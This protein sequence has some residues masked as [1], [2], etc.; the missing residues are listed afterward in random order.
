MNAVMENLLTR[1]SV[2]AFEKK[3]IPAE[4]LN[5]ILQAAIYA[6]SGMNRQTWQFTVVTDAKKIQALAAAVG[7]ALGR[8]GYDMY[9]PA[10]IVVTTNERTSRHG[11]DDNACAMENMFLAAHSFGIGSVWINQLRDCCDVPE[12]RAILKSWGIPDDHV[13]YGIAALGYA[14]PA[15]EKEIHK[16]GK[17]VF[18][19]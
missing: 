16:T 8:E 4:E 13:A 9:Q 6:P 10:A 3:E 11:I 5:Q 17:I 7:K 14:A 2:R 1:R 19:K 15:P 12:V 18:V